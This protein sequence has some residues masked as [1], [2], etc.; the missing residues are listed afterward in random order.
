MVNSNE[1]WIA[2]ADGIYR[3]QVSGGFP[4]DH[5]VVTI[6]VTMVVV[7]AAVVVWFFT[8]NRIAHKSTE[9]EVTDTKVQ[10]LEFGCRQ[11]NQKNIQFMSKHGHG[12]YAESLI[13]NKP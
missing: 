4:G 9:R 1:G 11:P 12:C 10:E 2:G 7:V 5:L 8:K 3:W 6:A 13:L